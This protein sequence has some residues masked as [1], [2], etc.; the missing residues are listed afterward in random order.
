MIKNCPIENYHSLSLLFDRFSLNKNIINRD[1]HKNMSGGESKK[2]ELA[3]ASIVI[4]K[5]L[6]LDEVDSGLDEQS[7]V[8]AAEVI[9]QLAKAGTGVLIISHDVSFL[10]RFKL[11]SKYLV[12]DK[13]LV[14]VGK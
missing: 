13:S 14:K 10:A 4:P 8:V 3:I 7:K 5:Y 12:Q 2:L 6:L 9:S 1:L 11:N